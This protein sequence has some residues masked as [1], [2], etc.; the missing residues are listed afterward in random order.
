E[1]HAQPRMARE[2]AARAE[3][4][5]GEHLLDRMGIDVLEHRVGAELLADLAKLRARPLVESER[6]LELLEGGPERLV[7]RIVPVPPVHLVRSQEHRAEA[8]LADAAPGLGDGVV[9]VE[10]RD[11]AGAEQAL[12]ILLAELMEPV[13]VRARHGRGEPPPALAVVG[14]PQVALVLREP[15]R[16]LGAEGR[17][18]VPRPEVR[19]LDDV[20]VAIE[21]LEFPLD[22]GSPPLRGTLT[23]SRLVVKGAGG[24]Y[25]I[26]MIPVIDLGPYLAGRPG[27]FAAIAAELGSALET[28]GFFV[29][30]G[31]GISQ[32]LIDDTFAEARR[33][34]GQ[35]MA[36]KLALRM[37]EHNNGYMV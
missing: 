4:A 7:V 9:D 11:H 1:R 20:N 2:D 29:V 19:R 25:L 6:D 12:W 30:V 26:V 36:D 8:V 21:D 31:H 15:D 14:Q 32:R 18:D 5:G 16:R 33:F 35:P 37:N 3:G 23:S 22:H 10:G 27:A 34:H 28:V 17:I 24:C 13:V